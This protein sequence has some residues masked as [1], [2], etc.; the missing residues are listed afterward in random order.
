MEPTMK[1]DSCC[2]AKGRCA[3]YVLG[4]IGTFLLMAALVWLMRHYTQTPNLGADRAQERIKN[5]KEMRA[6]NYEALH[7]YA[8]QDQAKGIVR[9]PIDR[10]MELTL[11]E[12]KNPAAARSNLIARMEKATAPAPKAPEKPSEFE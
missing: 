1:T 6:A 11:Q 7:N 9:L 8:W 10:A 4:I 2:A 12:W 3:A 5:L